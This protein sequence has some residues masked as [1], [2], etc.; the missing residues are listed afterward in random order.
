MKRIFFVHSRITLIMFFA[1]ILA[2]I[3]QS[4]RTHTYYKSYD[5]AQ[6]RNIHK[7]DYMIYDFKSNDLDNSFTYNHNDTISLSYKLHKYSLEG[8]E[9]FEI[10]IENLTNK[11]L[12]IDL[13]QSSFIRNGYSNPY[14]KYVNDQSTNFIPPRSYF[15][16]EVSPELNIEQ[17]MKS[18]Y[19]SMK[20]QFLNEKEFAESNSP[21]VYRNLMTFSNNKELEAP[22][23]IQNKIWVEKIKITQSKPYKD[24]SNEIDKTYRTRFYNEEETYYVK[25]YYVVNTKKKFA[26]FKLIYGIVY[27]AV[28]IGSLGLFYAIEWGE[29]APDAVFLD[30]Y[31]FDGKKR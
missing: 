27:Y 15:I 10:K 26:P 22:T 18:I 11:P 19:N 7:T 5:K 23:F 8:N 16:L 20:E 9:I 13:S 28:H 3:S 6:K 24:Y 1:G 29:L 2:I 14:R 4:C 12:Y 17:N 25:D 30:K 31:Y 21:I